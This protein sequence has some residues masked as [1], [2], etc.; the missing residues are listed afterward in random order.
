MFKF[1]VQVCKAKSYNYV[2][3]LSLPYKGLKTDLK[4]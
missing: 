2:A 3:L 4:H 1:N